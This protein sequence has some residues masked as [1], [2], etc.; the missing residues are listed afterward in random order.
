MADPVNQGGA[1]LTGEIKAAARYDIKTA[2]F[3][4][5]SAPHWSSSTLSNTWNVTR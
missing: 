1:V 4:F 3:A 5:E 2:A